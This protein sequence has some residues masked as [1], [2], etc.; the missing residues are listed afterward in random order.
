MTSAESIYAI[1]RPS[2]KL[3]WLYV[4]RV[5]ALGLL[6]PWFWIALLPLYF[7][8]HISSVRIDTAGGGGGGDKQQPFVSHRGVLAGIENA[9]EV[10]DR[11]L[12]LLQA[13]RDAGLGDHEPN[14][15]VPGGGLSAHA[16]EHLREVRD[17][18]RELRRALE[19]A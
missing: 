14:A 12:Q 13:Y 9:E 11:I 7:R 4:L 5:L 10:R 15:H 19:S 17:E 2:T 3:L 8:Y 1:E 16:L 18:A 6:G